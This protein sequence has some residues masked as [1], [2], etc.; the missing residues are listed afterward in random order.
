MTQ[1]TPTLL[2][3]TGESLY[4]TRWQSE[5]SRA[6]DVTDRTMRHL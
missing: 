3:E 2:R 6:L 1:L 4:G 5:L